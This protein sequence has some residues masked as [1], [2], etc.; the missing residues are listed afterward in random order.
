MS[1]SPQ[2]ELTFEQALEAL[3][4]IVRD[5]EDGQTGLEESLQRYETG[6]NLLKRCYA[7]LNQAEQRILQLTGTDETGKPVLQTFQHTAAVESDKPEPR[8][9]RKKSGEADELF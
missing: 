3:E 2:D 5:L 4:R 9:R 6:V 7:H 8:K 1:A